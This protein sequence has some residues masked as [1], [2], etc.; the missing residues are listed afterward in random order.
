[1]GSYFDARKLDSGFIYVVTNFNFVKRLFPWLNWGQGKISSILSKIFRFPIFSKELEGFNILSF[2]L[3]NPVHGGRNMITICAD[4][5]DNIYMSENHIYI[6]SS[7]VERGLDYSVIRKIFVRNLSII[8]FGTA[9]V[10]GTIKNQ[11][12]LDEY[13]QFLRVATTNTLGDKWNNVYILDYYCRAY[14]ALTGIAPGERILS[15]RYVEKRLYLTT[16]NEVDPFFVIEFS[17]LR[18]PRIL[19]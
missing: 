11:F 18:T 7:V 5:T 2:N 19:G 12:S 15:A 10:R 8:P 17:S 16:F 1:M 4:A 6:T 3:A 9:K 13:G 14:G